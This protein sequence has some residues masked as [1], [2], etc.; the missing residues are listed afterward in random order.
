[1]IPPDDNLGDDVQPVRDLLS[2]YRPEASPLEL[3][4]VKRRVLARA[5]NGSPKT[6]S[7]GFMRSRA[8]ILTTLVLGFVLSSTG[9]GLAISGFSGNEQASVAQYPDTPTVQ[10]QG[11]PNVPEQTVQDE[12]EQVLPGSEEADVAP[13]DD[14]V[15]VPRQVAAGVPAGE[16]DQLPFTGFAAIP[17]LLIGLA[18]LGGGAV[19]R[20]ASQND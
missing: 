17:V 5:A 16:G 13:A 11:Q 3:D 7:N 19:M 12:P 10:P 4:A 9:A 8:A 1:M 2:V 15:Q 18:L 14:E 20:R 6:R